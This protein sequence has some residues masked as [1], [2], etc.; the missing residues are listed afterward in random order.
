MCYQAD[1]QPRE[2]DKYLM[3]NC[4]IKTGQELILIPIHNAPEYPIS[5]FQQICKGEKELAN[6]IL[7]QILIYIQYCWLYN[8][9]IYELQVWW[10]FYILA[11]IS[12]YRVSLFF[13]IIHKEFSEK[14]VKKPL[15]E[16]TLAI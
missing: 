7:C 12:L 14:Y 8:S 10:S 2:R 4:R 6:S 15:I 11:V 5:H 13:H 3:E 9:N 1:H 16:N